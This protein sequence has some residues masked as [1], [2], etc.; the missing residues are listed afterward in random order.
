MK[1]PALRTWTPIEREPTI[2]V[3]SQS[4]AVQL[5][6]TRASRR[7][8]G[9]PAERR[10]EQLTEHQTLLYQFLE[11]SCVLLNTWMPTELTGCEQIQLINRKQAY[12]CKQQQ[13][14]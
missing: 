3:P 12:V 6:G 1:N 13:N 5:Q 8:P 4:D 10:V 2:N 7:P 11:S 9:G 14:G